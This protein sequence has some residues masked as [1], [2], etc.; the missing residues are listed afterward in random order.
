M[1]LKVGD[2]APK[3]NLSDQ[4]GKKHSLLDYKKKWIL[5]YFYP[6]DNTPGCTKEA[7]TIRDNYNEFKK[8][9]IVVFGVSNDTIEKHKK[10]AEKFEL[11][12]TLLADTEKNLVKSYGVW[13]KKK[14]MGKEYFGISRSSFLI[15]PKGIIAKIYEKVKPAD[16]ASEIL[17]DI[18]LLK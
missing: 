1:K 16:H 14:F 4:N 11:P 2:K 7:C 6:R 5:L 3:F 18:K 10:F 12:F 9:K 8:N 17:N 15:S 13:S